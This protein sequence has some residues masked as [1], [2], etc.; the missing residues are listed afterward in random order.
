M[1]KPWWTMAIGL[2]V[3]SVAGCT[4]SDDASDGGQ[5]TTVGTEVDD[6]EDALLGETL[7]TGSL[8]FVVTHPD[9]DDVTYTLR[10]SGDDATLTGDVP[11]D[12]FLA[13]ERVNSPAVKERLISGRPEAQEC[14]EIYGSADE[15]TVTGTIDDQPVDTTFD[16]ANGCGIDEWDILMSGV[17]PLPQ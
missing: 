2:T 6:P 8:D 17:L 11:L 7:A 13:C 5:V 10:C 15:A 3:V 12:E 1:G 16:R 4:G 9:R 14:P